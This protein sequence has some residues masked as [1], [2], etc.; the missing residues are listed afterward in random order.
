M[1]LRFFYEALPVI[2]LLVLVCFFGLFFFP[3]AGRVLGRTDYTYLSFGALC[4]FWG[5][6][7]ILQLTGGEDLTATAFLMN[8]VTGIVF[9]ILVGFLL[10]ELKKNR[11]ILYFLLSWIPLILTLGVDILDRI[12]H[13]PGS[14]FFR[15]GMAVTMV[16]QII[17]LIYDLRQQYLE[18]LKYERLQKELYEAEVAVMVSQIQPHFMYNALTSIAMMCINDPKKAQE[19]TV[20]FAKY[21]RGN[22]DSLKQKKPVPFRQELEHLQKYL[23]IEKMRFGKRL[24][25]EYDIEPEELLIVMGGM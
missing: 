4:F 23:Y 9:L 2:L 21:L 3:I 11:E 15:Y 12:I 7:M 19:A 22:M 10:F 14:Y 25:V 20:T 17:G 5:F 13:L 8:I 16:V 24:N 1:Y 6:Y 18:R